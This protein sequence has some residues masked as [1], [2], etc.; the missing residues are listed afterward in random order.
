M[1]IVVVA[2]ADATRQQLE[3]LGEVKVVPMPARRGAAT[4][5]TTPELLKPAGG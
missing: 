2:P 4:E 1:T 5:P 3:A